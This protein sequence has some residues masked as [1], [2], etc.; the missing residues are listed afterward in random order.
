[1]IDCAPRQGLVQ[2][3]SYPLWGCIAATDGIGRNGRR[4]DGRLEDESMIEDI[5]SIFDDKSSPWHFKE[6]VEE[7]VSFPEDEFEELVGAAKELVDSAGDSLVDDDGLHVPWDLFIR[8]EELGFDARNRSGHTI[9]RDK[10]GRQILRRSDLKK[11][12]YRLHR[13]NVSGH[14]IQG[15]RAL[16]QEESFTK[17]LDSSFTE[18]KKKSEKSEGSTMTSSTIS[19]KDIVCMSALPMLTTH[20][21]DPSKSSYSSHVHS[22]SHTAKY[23]EARENDKENRGY[24]AASRSKSRSR[25]NRRDSDG[26]AEDIEASNNASHGKSSTPRLWKEKRNSLDPYG[27]K[28]SLAT[29][30]SSTRA[31]SIDVRT[32]GQTTHLEP[33]S[34]A[35]NMPRHREKMGTIQHQDAYSTPYYARI[36]KFAKVVKK[37]R[38]NLTQLGELMSNKIVE[39]ARPSHHGDR[40]GDRRL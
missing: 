32:I 25:L 35:E 34:H 3:C 24:N 26:L 13:L 6:H 4:Q 39:K 15:D 10:S 14:N 5:I 36:E 37:L 12:N 7:G 31:T 38:T 8:L 28:I 33:I 19:K 27:R 18:E 40:K 1:M 17:L 30:P 20:D 16:P 2:L 22:S 23:R 9:V 21:L 11:S 29:S